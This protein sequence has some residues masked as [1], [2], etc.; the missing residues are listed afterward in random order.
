MFH[1][2]W[3]ESHSAAES[4]ATMSEICLESRENKKEGE[5]GCSTKRE[6]LDTC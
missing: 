6:V 5:T 2:D 3:A 1:V 4:A